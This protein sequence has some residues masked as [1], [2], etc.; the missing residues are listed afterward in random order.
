[1]IYLKRLLQCIILILI[2]SIV[3]VLAISSNKSKESASPSSAP[4]SKYEEKAMK[5]QKIRKEWSNKFSENPA[6]VVSEIED[7][8]EKEDYEGAK[9]ILSYLPSVS[10]PKLE[11][12]MGDLKYK[13]AWE[14]VPWTKLPFFFSRFFS[15]LPRHLT[16]T[17]HAHRHCVC[18]ATMRGVSSASTRR[19]GSLKALSL[20]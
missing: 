4:L 19:I 14:S 8:I 1:M 3:A 10:D 20:P 9:K 15:L 12:I 7:R 5:D 18:Q 2:C 11:K 6:I 16:Q 13:I 17:P